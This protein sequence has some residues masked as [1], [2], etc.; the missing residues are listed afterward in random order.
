[1]V[2]RHMVADVAFK[3]TVSQARSMGCLQLCSFHTAIIIIP[4][5][6]STVQT[7]PPTFLY[8]SVSICTSHEG[9]EHRQLMSSIS[10]GLS[11]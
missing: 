11:C 7:H 8:G 5:Y 1:M 10:D 9:Q 3:L 2:D 6:L 4:K